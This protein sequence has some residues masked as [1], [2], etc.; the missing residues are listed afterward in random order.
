MKGV[1]PFTDEQI[2]NMCS[3]YEAG[4]SIEALSEEYGISSTAIQ[5]RL[6]RNGVKIRS[7]GAPR[8]KRNELLLAQISEMRNA[9]MT[10]AQICGRLGM[11]PPT[12]YNRINMQG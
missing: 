4:A 9:G 2:A 11:S 8:L 7:R 5:Y 1:I 12:Y 6:R 10:I 3:S